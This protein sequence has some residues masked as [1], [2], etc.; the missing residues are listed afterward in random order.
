[1]ALKKGPTRQDIPD[2]MRSLKD[3]EAVTGTISITPGG[4]AVKGAVLLQVV[5]ENGK[6]V[7]RLV[8]KIPAAQ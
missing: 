7:S 5:K 8:K 2:A 1:E 4:D 3:I 6:H